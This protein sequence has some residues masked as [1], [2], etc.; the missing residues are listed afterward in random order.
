M[1]APV[2]SDL[3]ASTSKPDVVDGVKAMMLEELVRFRGSGVYHADIVCRG[4]GQDA[5]EAGRQSTHFETKKRHRRRNQ[6]LVRVNSQVVEQQ[7][8]DLLRVLSATA[9]VTDL[10]DLRGLRRRYL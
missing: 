2:S 6:Y 9:E 10:R 3:S 5:G 8:P 7:P 1:L 4:S